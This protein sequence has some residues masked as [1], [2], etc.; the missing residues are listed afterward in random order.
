LPPIRVR[1]SCKHRFRLAL[2]VAV[3]ALAV[4]AGRA[5]ESTRAPGPLRPHPTN[6]RYFTDGTRGPDGSPR[7]VYLAGSHVWQ[8]FQD[9]GHR[10]ESGTEPPPVFDYP[11]FLDL[12][13]RHGHNFTRLWRW[14]MPK[15]TERDTASKMTEYSRPHPWA[16]T[17][18]GLAYDG[19]P[20]FDLTRFDDA[21]FARLRSRVQLAGERGIYVAVMLFELWGVTHVKNAWEFHPFAAANNVN[22]IE[23]DENAD[24]SGLEFHTLRDT[25]TS[26]Q[27]RSLQEAYVR[28][29]I[30]TLNECDNVLYEIGN[31]GGTYTL[32]W[33]EHMVDVIHRAE[34][35]QP[36]QHP[37]GITWMFHRDSERVAHGDNASLLRCRA[38]WISPG[39]DRVQ[40][41]DRNPPV[42][43]PGR[44]IIAD[45][46]HLGWRSPRDH[47][48]F[49]KQF[50]R[51][52]HTLYL[53]WSYTSPTVGAASREGMGQ[54]VR[55]SRKVNL[56]AMQPSATVASTT[57]ALAA[58]GREYLIYQPAAGAFSVDLTPSTATFSAAWFIPATGESRPGADVSGG[59]RREFTP[60][61]SGPVVLHLK[62]KS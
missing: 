20:K 35:A 26:R 8:N 48:W 34:A 61:H 58:P 54:V 37:A 29:V 12:L 46:D 16:R 52:Q 44:L 45:T 5:A 28:R 25:A 31:E 40:D 13:Q 42:E 6:P 10:L 56:A 43:F 14:E 38:D 50:C 19:Q 55:R 60:P 24:G 41:F 30:A 2:L 3:A 39:N 59:A 27:V 18:P 17:G 47:G 22:G 32:A 33:Q 15:W 9:T 4:T 21:Y 23:A 62:A 1:F 11:A 51:G 7:A 53:E 57:F 36:K 49:W